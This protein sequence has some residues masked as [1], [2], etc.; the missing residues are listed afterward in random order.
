MLRFKKVI[1]IMV[2]LFL[3][4][5]CSTSTSRLTLEPKPYN[6]VY[7]VAAAKESN[8]KL[9]IRVAILKVTSYLKLQS[10]VN[11]AENTNGINAFNTQS[12]FINSL[13]ASIESII[14][15]KGYNIIDLV[16]SYNELT[17]E[18]I[19]NID[20]LIVPKINLNAVE[21]INMSSKIPLDINFKRDA[22]GGVS[23]KGKVS[24]E[25]E[26]AFTILNPKTNDIIYS[27]GS[28]IKDTS[29]LNV[30]V[31]KYTAGQS[32]D[33]LYKGLLNRCIS[34][35]NN[36]RSKTLE[37][38]YESYIKAFIKYFPEGKS[39]EKL[40]GNIKAL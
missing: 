28:N 40:F 23:C 29:P 18:Q 32:A 34:G 25:G 27:K 36:A 5:S 17:K 20:F 6:P 30:S 9:D 10:N 38:I 13:E 1:Y 4:N 24:L 33:E 15:N 14:V 2:L 21:D 8:Q 19:D 35:V 7:K 3:F 37:A 11:M 22:R 39:A 16:D 31:E 26:M 12:E